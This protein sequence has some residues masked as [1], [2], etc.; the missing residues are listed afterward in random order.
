[1]PR[2]INQKNINLSTRLDQDASVKQPNTT[3]N[4]RQALVKS[5]HNINTN[6]Y[7]STG[8]L[9]LIV[10]IAIIIG[11]QKNNQ[12]I[13]KESGTTSV[14]ETSTSLNPS[15][16]MP[17]VEDTVTVGI[18]ENSE[19]LKISDIL[20]QGYQYEI[21]RKHKH[22]KLVRYP[23]DQNR[24]EENAEVIAT[25]WDGDYT[26][27]SDY[28]FN[29]SITDDILTLE[30]SRKTDCTDCIS[31]IYRI[32]GQNIDRLVIP[33]E[34]TANYQGYHYATLYNYIPCDGYCSDHL[35]ITQTHLVRL[36]VN[37]NTTID[38]SQIVKSFD[39]AS[40][41]SFIVSDEI[42][43]I[44]VGC[45][46]CMGDGGPIY[47]LSADG[48]NLELIINPNNLS[49]SINDSYLAPQ[50]IKYIYDI[51]TVPPCLGNYQGSLYY[52][53]PETNRLEKIVEIS[54]DDG[55]I[56]Y[57]RAKDDSLIFAKKAAFS[58]EGSCP[59]YELNE[60]YSLQLDPNTL[61][62]AKKTH[63]TKDQLA[64]QMHDQT[65]YD[66]DTDMFTFF[67]NDE[68]RSY[69]VITSE[70]NSVFDLSPYIAPYQLENYDTQYI[71][72][73][74]SSLTNN[75]GKKLYRYYA[76]YEYPEQS[77]IDI[78]DLIFDFANRSVLTADEYFAQ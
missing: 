37:Q 36:P 40:V 45:T 77:Q 6:K 62:I 69:N 2:L 14:S 32:S 59:P 47:R 3:P 75:D 48:S 71:N 72:R 52:Y 4:I 63:L 29:F 61:Q 10:L 42:L 16:N 43:Y 31:E 57:G 13:N 49:A 73:H 41:F 7:V 76:F 28:L 1:M 66:N 56:F 9:I 54:L 17:S 30:V 74:V 24:T 5:L 70:Y 64:G 25:Y 51:M 53:L 67:I 39:G 15:R 23:I 55:I 38:N 12:I 44:K 60:I 20:Y 11:F 33:N 58:Q 65:F 26:D 35:P 34:Q 18:N 50:K 8:L 21:I 68:V 78:Y 19:P 46:D 27:L 22:T